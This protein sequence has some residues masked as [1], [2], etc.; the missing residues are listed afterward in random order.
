MITPKSIRKSLNTVLTDI[1]NCD[2]LGTI[3]SIRYSVERFDESLVAM[4]L[5][6]GLET[7]DILY[8][9]VNRK[10][11][12]RRARIGRNQFACRH[13]FDWEDDLV[14]EPQIQ[15]Y[16]TESKEWYAQNYGDYL[17]YHASNQSL[18]QTIAKI[19]SDFFSLELKKF[20]SLLK[21]ANEECSPIFP[22]SLNGTDQ[23]EEAQ[24]DCLSDGMI[25]C[26]YRCLDGLTA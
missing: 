14:T 22:C 1:I 25:G 18:D 20:R 15:D 2:T 11:Q 5:L 17:L 3:S 10:E 12:W 8:F 9:A 13:S 19:G 21:R 4:Q 24:Y 26:G 7:S 6:L 23:F 16:V